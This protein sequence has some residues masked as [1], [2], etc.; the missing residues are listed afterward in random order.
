M[1]PCIVASQRLRIAS[2]LSQPN[3]C[4]QYEVRSHR[5]YKSHSKVKQQRIRGDVAGFKKFPNHRLHSM[6]H[7]YSKAQD[8]AAWKHL[9]LF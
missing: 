6:Q 8:A 4:E 1:A 7:W 9:F 2:P 5:R 3:V